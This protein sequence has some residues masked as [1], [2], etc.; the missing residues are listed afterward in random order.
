MVFDTFACE[1]S[2]T[3]AAATLRVLLEALRSRR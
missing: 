3:R 1:Q 2:F